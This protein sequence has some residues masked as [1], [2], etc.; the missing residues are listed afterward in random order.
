VART[1]GGAFGARAVEKRYLALVRGW[2]AP[3]GTIEHPLSR[4]FDDVEPEFARAAGLEARPAATSFVRLATIELPIAVDRY[5]AS[6]YALLQ[7]TPHT[8]RRHQIRRHLKHVSHPIV[9]D[10]TYGKGRH[11]RA[12]AALLGV[13]RL[14][15]H[16]ES[17]S[18]IHPS[19]GT[20][21]TITAP[22]DDAWRR[23][24]ALAQWA[25][26]DAWRPPAA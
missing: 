3:V 5:P 24:L 4:R 9:G 20:T 7:V 17:I 11:N 19:A 21:L 18:F 10:A 1:L 23:L 12:M 16:A 2:P 26:D 8:G 22:P 6:R 14:W 15:L 25:W 13:Q